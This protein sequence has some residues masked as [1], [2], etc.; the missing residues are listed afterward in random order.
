MDS[1][2]QVIKDMEDQIEQLMTEYNSIPELYSIKF[3]A[4]ADA[5]TPYLTRLKAL[6]EISNDKNQPN[7]H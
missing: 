7:E 6:R 2:D 4:G 5:L 3:K 1:I